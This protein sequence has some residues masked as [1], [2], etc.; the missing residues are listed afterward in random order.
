MKVIAQRYPRLYINISSK[1]KGYELDYYDNQYHNDGTLKLNSIL[2]PYEKFISRQ[3][4]KQKL[5][6]LNKI[7]FQALTNLVKRQKK[8]VEIYLSKDK[9]EQYR[10]VNSSLELLF[11][12]Q[13]LFLEWFSSNKIL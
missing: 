6:N 4:D 10:I 12:Y 3:S 11:E 2:I 7:E 9:K 1:E 13:K 8:V 5:Y